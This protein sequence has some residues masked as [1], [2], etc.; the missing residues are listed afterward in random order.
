MEYGLFYLDIL[1]SY[2]FRISTLA[3]GDI[4]DAFTTSDSPTNGSPFTM[5]ETH[6]SNMWGPWWYSNAVNCAYVRLLGIITNGFCF[7]L[8]EDVFLKYCRMM[9]QQIK[10]IKKRQIVTT[11]MVLKWLGLL[12]AS[13][14][15]IE[16]QRPVCVLHRC[17][18]ARTF[19]C[20]C[21]TG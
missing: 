11:K 17:V 13:K 19:S 2:V 3:V 6:C 8:S 5:S 18:E 12:Y 14:I 21:L 9:I 16:K 10:E 4:S 20:S 1:T 15:S 7:S